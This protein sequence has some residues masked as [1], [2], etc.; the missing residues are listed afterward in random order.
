MKAVLIPGVVLIPE[1]V[2]IPGTVVIPG[3]MLMAE[4]HAAFAA[5][6]VQPAAFCLPLLSALP[7]R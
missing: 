7:A 5:A 4:G 2:V 6:A 3:V 1:A